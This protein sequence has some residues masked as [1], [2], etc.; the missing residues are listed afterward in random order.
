MASLLA[1]D[2]RE[3]PVSDTF[4]LW[5]NKN[6]SNLNPVFNKILSG[7]GRVLQRRGRHQ[8]TIREIEGLEF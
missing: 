4:W 3:K 2:S 6:L 7:S 5:L 1:Y 8:S